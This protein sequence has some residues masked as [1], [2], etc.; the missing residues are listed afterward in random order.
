MV[1][2]PVYSVK[3]VSEISVGHRLLLWSGVMR[4]FL[5]YVFNK[6]YVKESVSKCQGECLRCGACCKLALK[7]CPYLAFDANG[8]SSCTKYDISRM[9]NCVVFPIDNRDIKERDIVSS[10]PCGYSFSADNA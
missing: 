9:P 5:L 2:R 8:K 4:R 1:K 6:K 3:S 10:T 7:Q